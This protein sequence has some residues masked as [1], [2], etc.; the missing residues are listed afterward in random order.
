MI[1][2]NLCISQNAKF[3]FKGNQVVAMNRYNGEWI[4]F[5]KEC[6]GYLKEGLE[7]GI[8]KEEF[9]ACFIDDED[10]AYMKKLIEMLE[11]IN[12]IVK[13]DEKR[14]ENEPQLDSVQIAL[15]NRCNLQCKHCATNAK[16]VNGKD[17]LNA[18]DI[19]EIIDKL[20][21]CHVKSIILSGGEPLIRNDFFEILHYIRE[22]DRNVKITLMT[23]ALLINR[24]NVKDIAENVDSID[25]S[26]DGYDDESCSSIRGENVFSRVLERVALL[27]ENGM[28]RISLSMV[29]LGRDQEGEMKFVSLCK[30][31]CVIP[32]IRR[33]SFMGRA[34]DNVEYF[35]ELEK[36]RPIA[37]R[38]SMS[39]EKCRDAIKA[40]SC[41]AGI[42]MININECGL[43]YPCNTFDHDMEEIG[44]IMEIESLHDFL[45]KRMNYITDNDME[46]YKYNPYYEKICSDCCVRYFCWTCPYAVKDFQREHFDLSA[47][48]KGKKEDLYSIVWGENLK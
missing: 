42:K 18:K 11:N 26:L 25:I 35:K 3:L 19:K 39:I 7:L 21:L 9:L 34:K 41:T 33:L 13:S 6:Y 24:V 28:K 23:N 12:V 38:V 17:F 5:T 32:M 8:T 4:R 2:N 47:Y 30:D 44:N 31:L 48:C 1:E 45:K 46:F 16:T 27:Q 43:M 20:T 22:K 36:D 37:N 14:S 29:S 15:T 10:R 40:C